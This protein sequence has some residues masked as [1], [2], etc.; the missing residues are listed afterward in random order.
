MK[1]FRLKS[2]IVIFAALIIFS[3][4]EKDDTEDSN[5]LESV[6]DIVAATSYTDWVYYSFSE[7]KT[8][9]ITD[10]KTSTSWDIGL[11]RNHIRTNSGSSGNGEGGAYD[12]GTINFDTFIEAPETGYAIDDSVQAFNFA[13]MQYSPV[14]ANSVL[15]TWGTFTDAQ[16]PVLEPSNK[17]FVI[18]T[19]E[20]KYV[21]I[22]VLNYYGTEGSGYITFKYTYQPD[23]SRKLE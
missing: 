1:N 2:V 16:P 15:E 21:K 6:T 17:V 12:A 22:I 9:E 3:A 14:A 11:L 18:K 7:G 10:P 4:C 23:G 13:T 20:G 8:I 5:K 19:A